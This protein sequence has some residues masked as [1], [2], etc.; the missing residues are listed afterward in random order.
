MKVLVA[1]ASRHGST[2]GIA[3]RIAATL[4]DAGLEAES[5]PVKDVRS[6]DGY[7]AFVVGSAAYM[8]R[9]LGDGTSFVK[10]NR[11]ALA[12][13]PVWLFTCGPL[14][15]EGLDEHGRDKRD[16]AVPKA[17]PDLASSIGARDHHVFF[18]AY[19]AHQPPIGLAERFMSLMP[20][21]KE[22][23]PQG[24][25]RDWAEIEGW[26]TGIAND[27]RSPVGAG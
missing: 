10:R 26:A 18:G 7:D 11:A 12:A 19:D 23:L 16:A 22:G 13:K 4:R 1:F 3:D 21:A 27:L 9:W 5:R 24:D 17:I 8:F 14:G 15:P 20:A 2:A 25:F 6:V